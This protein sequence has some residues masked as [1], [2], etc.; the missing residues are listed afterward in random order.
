MKQKINVHLSI[1]F[2]GAVHKDTLEVD[3]D[4]DATEEEANAVKDEVTQEWANN[5]LDIAWS[6][7][8]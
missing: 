7:I 5:F 8:E 4:D 2:V 1:G 6:D 3:I